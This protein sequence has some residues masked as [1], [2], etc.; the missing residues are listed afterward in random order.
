MAKFNT[1]YFVSILDQ[2]K[3]DSKIYITVRWRSTHFVLCDKI[4]TIHAVSHFELG[5]PLV[6]VRS[7]LDSH[8]SHF[9]DFR[10]TD[11]NPLMYIVCLSRPGARF[12]SAS[13]FVE[14][15]VYSTMV[16][17]PLKKEKEIQP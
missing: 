11:L 4:C 16:A 1:V 13:G 14:P 17:I 5:N 9:G 3:Y 6:K 10:K 12:A 15:G 7:A 8:G 2:V